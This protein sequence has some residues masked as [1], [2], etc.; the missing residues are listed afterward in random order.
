[1]N[2]LLM[3]LVLLFSLAPSLSIAQEEDD[4]PLDL[5]VS[6]IQKGLMIVQTE[7][8]EESIPQLKSVEMTFQ[9]TKSIKKGGKVKILVFSF[10]KEWSS[11]KSHKV[12]IKLVPPKPFSKDEISSEKNVAK[13]LSDLIINTSRAIQD[14][15]SGEPPLELSEFTTELNFVTVRG[16]NGGVGVEFDIIPVTVEA[17]GNLEN[18]AIHTISVTYGK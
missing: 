12:K 4:I 7:L 6:E 13:D 2:N 11:E 14:M 17:S 5:V 9:T 16:T 18:K 1:M 8:A 3:S 10:G 15:E